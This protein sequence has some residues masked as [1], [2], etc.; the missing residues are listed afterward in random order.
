M[1]LYGTPEPTNSLIL[2]AVSGPVL[3]P[4]DTSVGST[5]VEKNKDDNATSPARRSPGP[6]GKN[7]SSASVEVV[8]RPVPLKTPRNPLTPGSPIP[9]AIR[10]LL[11]LGKGL[12]STRGSLS[13]RK[14]K[15]MN[16]SPVPEGEREED[17]E[18]DDDDEERERSGSS[19]CPVP[20]PVSAIETQTHR[21]DYMTNVLDWL[22]CRSENLDF[23]CG[24]ERPQRS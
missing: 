21:S 13:I 15:Q 14:N 20:T 11:S 17:N 19:C 6:P 23:F 1:A 24:S 4:V 22:I 3:R 8:P 7:L 10:P 18:E 5:E 16:H 9:D 12:V 2:I